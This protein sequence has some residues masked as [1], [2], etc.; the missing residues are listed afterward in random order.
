MYFQ[1][2]SGLEVEFL[3][4]GGEELAIFSWPV[5]AKESLA[6]TRSEKDILA[7]LAQ[8]ASN[9]EIARARRTSIRTVANQIAK[10]LRKFGVRSRYELARH[11]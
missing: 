4:I 1:P 7:M 9:A 2:P 10:L 5:A 3:E 11:F 6:L 8:G